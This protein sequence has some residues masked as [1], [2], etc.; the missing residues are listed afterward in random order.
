MKR[1]IIIALLIVALLLV[2]AGISTVIFFS[3]QGGFSN[4]NPFDTR[5]IASELE[6]SYGGIIRG[7]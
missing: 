2:G 5:N 4:N 6:E 7:Q 3:F 1:P